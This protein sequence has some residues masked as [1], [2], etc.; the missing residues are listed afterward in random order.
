MV[1]VVD[2]HVIAVTEALD[3]VV[4]LVEGDVEVAGVAARRLELETSRLY[5]ASLDQRETV[6]ADERGV[7]RHLVEGDITDGKD[8]DGVDTINLMVALCVSAKDDR[9]KLASAYNDV[10]VVVKDVAPSYVPEFHLANIAHP[11]RRR[12][13]PHGSRTG[14]LRGRPTPRV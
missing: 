5:D 1:R 3:T 4:E 14:T 13:K 8:R 12:V 6:E 10:L 7:L 9:V 11:R 2:D